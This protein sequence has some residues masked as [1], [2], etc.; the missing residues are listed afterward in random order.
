MYSILIILIIVVIVLTIFIFAVTGYILYN[1]YESTIKIKEKTD[2]LEDNLLI[3]AKYLT[4]TQEQAEALEA[5]TE[6]L[7]TKI[8]TIGQLC[9]LA[10]AQYLICTTQR[11]VPPPPGGCSPNLELALYSFIVSPVC[12]HLIT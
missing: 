10:L 5:N 3:S 7:S 1:S 2:L 4:D 6:E 8:P 9:N 12:E 11:P